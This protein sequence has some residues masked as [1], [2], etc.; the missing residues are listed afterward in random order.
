MNRRIFLVV[1]FVV[2][3]LAASCPAS[4][5]GELRPLVVEIPLGPSISQCNRADPNACATL[6]GCNR[7]INGEDFCHDP[8]EQFVETFSVRN[9]GTESVNITA[10]EF[11]TSPDGG[12]AEN[13][14]SPVFD[15]KLPIQ[16]FADQAASL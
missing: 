7:S 6:G 4:K 10:V 16:L 14:T 1:S 5:P 8:S 15:K 11:A 3:A 9:I 13:F 12:G 2:V